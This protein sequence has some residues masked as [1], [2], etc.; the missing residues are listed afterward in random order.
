[1]EPLPPSSVHAG[2]RVCA[3]NI[4]AAIRIFDIRRALELWATRNRKPSVNNG[5]TEGRLRSKTHS[6]GTGVRPLSRASISAGDNCWSVLT[7]LRIF[8]G[9]LKPLAAA[10]SDSAG[11]LAAWTVLPS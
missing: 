2:G 7:S 10:E 8:L 9:P 3:Q 1:M 4:H 11:S 5:I 6:K